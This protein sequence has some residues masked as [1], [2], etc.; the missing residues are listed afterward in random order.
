MPYKGS[1]S[2]SWIKEVKVNEMM[3]KGEIDKGESFITVSKK[4]QSEDSLRDAPEEEEDEME[5]DG[6]TDV[7]IFDKISKKQR[8]ILPLSLT[9]FEIDGNSEGNNK[10][11]ERRLY[12]N[13]IGSMTV[14]ESNTN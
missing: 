8:I 1:S 3:E 4:E 13:N 14:F 12:E 9:T 7:I 11:D 10:T 6:R 2:Q 5:V